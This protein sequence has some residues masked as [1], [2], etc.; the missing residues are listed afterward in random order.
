[1]GEPTCLI[2]EVTFQGVVRFA[3]QNLKVGVRILDIFLQVPMTCF[4]FLTFTSR[5]MKQWA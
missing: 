2:K 3:F 1:M 4:S 5:K